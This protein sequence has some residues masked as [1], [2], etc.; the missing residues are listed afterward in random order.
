MALMEDN[1]TKFPPERQEEAQPLI[2]TITTY[3]KIYR[4]KSLCYRFK[5]NLI[6]WRLIKRLHIVEM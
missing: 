4:G 6:L 5:H 1:Y 3:P 2:K